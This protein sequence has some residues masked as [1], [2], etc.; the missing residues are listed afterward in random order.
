MANRRFGQRV[1]S[2]KASIDGLSTDWTE[3]SSTSCVDQRLVDELDRKYIDESL[4]CWSIDACTWHLVDVAS[5]HSSI[6][7]FSHDVCKEL[8][9]LCVVVKQT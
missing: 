8:S 7:G 1:P 3:K 5:T 4:I 6:D 9:E 2:I